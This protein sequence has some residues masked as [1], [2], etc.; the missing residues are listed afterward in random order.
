MAATATV[1]QVTTGTSLIAEVFSAIRDKVQGRSL[2]TDLQ[3][4]EQ[5]LR[6]D[7][8]AWE[9]LV[10]VHSRRVYSMCYRFTGSDTEAQDLTQEVFLRVFR[11]L[12][13]FRREEGSFSVWL[14]RLTRNL[15][16]D[17][18]RRAKYD[19]ATGSIEDH[20]PMLET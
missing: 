20:L 10:T 14:G 11:S 17:N 13:T 12:K 19:R 16:I 18:Y 2:D 5:C 1:G 7:Q 4:V 6:G 15:L 8:A 9:A 3:I